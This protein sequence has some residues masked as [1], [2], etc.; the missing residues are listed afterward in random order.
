M[1]KYRLERIVPLDRRNT[2]RMCELLC[3][4]NPAKNTF[5]E[6]QF[7]YLSLPELIS[8]IFNRR[9]WDFV[10]VNVDAAQIH[11]PIIFHSLIKCTRF[12]IVLEWTENIQNAHL[13]DLCETAGLFRYFQKKYNTRIFL[14]D[15]GS[16]LDGFGRACKIKPDAIKIDG[17]IFQTSTN[18]LFVRNL[19]QSYIETYKR[20]KILVI[21]EWIEE[22]ND[23]NIAKELDADFGQGYYWTEKSNMIESSICNLPKNKIHL[24]SQNTEKV[25]VSS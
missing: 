7:W 6:W 10:T 25:F 17:D 22:K 4:P 23:I 24:F 5:A 20:S 21:V 14:D 3:R 12:P 9:K 2:I 16:G 18:N 19:L 1:L 15:V 13:F 11:N 8:E